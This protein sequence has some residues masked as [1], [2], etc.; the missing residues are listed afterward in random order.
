MPPSRTQPQTFLGNVTEV[1]KQLHAKV[2][3][4][5][6]ALNP[7]ARVPELWVQT[8]DEENAQIY[9]LVGDRYLLGRSSQCDMV[10]PTSLVSK[11]HFSLSRDSREGKR[12]FILRD[13]GSTNGVYLG[14]RRLR[15]LQLQHGDVLTLGPPDLADAVRVQFYDPPP[16][17]VRGFRWSLYGVSGACALAT[18]L[19]LAEWQKFTV[20]PLPRSITGPTI[21]YSRDAERPLREPYS[22]THV[23]HPS[24]AE[25]GDYL[26]NAVIASEDSRFFW[27]LG[28]DPIGVL[29]AFVTNLRGGGI[30]EGA[31][32]VTQQL[33]RSLYRDYVGTEDSAGRKLREMIVALKLETFYSKDDL[34]LTY[35]NQVFLG[36]D[37]YGFEDAA[38]FY[39]GKSTQELSLS[40]AATLAGILPAP[41]RFN[42]IQ[43]YELA[44]QY[45]NRVIERMRALGKISQ[46]EADRARRS[47]IEINPAAREI[48]ESTVAPYFYDHVFVE[49]EQLLGSEL[50]REGNFIVETGLNPDLQEQ[51]EQSL[52]EYVRTVGT[53]LGVSQGAIVSLDYRTGEI[54]ALAGGVDYRSSQYNRA[55]QARRQPGSTFKVFP[56]AAALNQGISPGTV[57]SCQPLTWQGQSYRPCERSG[58]DINMYQGMAQ[59]ENVVALRIA[60]EAGLNNVVRLARELGIRSELDAVPGLALG[61]SEVSLLEITG[62]YG[63]FANQGRWNRGHAIRRILDSSDCANADDFQTCRVIYDYA[64]QEPMNQAVISPEVAG[65]MTNLL[66]GVVQ[67]GTGTA[68]AFGAGEVGKTGTTDF[69]VDL[70]FIGYVPQGSL[71]TGVW[72]GND[73]N[74]RTYGSSS[75]AAELWRSYMSRVVD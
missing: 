70:W 27:H 34:L 5:Q 58:G 52:Q 8:G 62:A 44:L 30:R 71:V 6:L 55:T 75:H 72:L 17:Y 73:D 49:L 24:L 1:A 50:A 47:R 65:I 40:E 13:E 22:T 2:N 15:K 64:Q 61:Q 74:S 54:V 25:F 9:P 63:I 48:L 28:V 67:S 23:E 26:P 41:N 4:G 11:T 36:I 57:F 31:S 60:R 3:F 59:S 19:V 68:A 46:E 33:A 53:Q 10:V 43:N 51:A 21:V 38:R 35:L 66:R 45:R 18:L 37:L 7:K 29:R 42:P 12:H 39:F 56:F 16:W 69:A 14:K 20:R 32:T